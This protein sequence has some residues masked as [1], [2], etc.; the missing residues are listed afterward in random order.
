MKGFFGL[1]GKLVRSAGSSAVGTATVLGVAG[2]MT[3]GTEG[4]PQLQG[5]TLENPVFEVNE[6]R[7]LLG[8]QLDG[9]TTFFLI[10]GGAL[11]LTLIAAFCCTGWGC[12]A[13]RELSK[14][15]AK[16]KGMKE[17]KLEQPENREIPKD[18]DLESAMSRLRSKMGRV[19]RKGTT[20]P[21]RGGGRDVFA[22]GLE[23]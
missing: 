21:E 6:S 11:I 18:R 4:G 15:R 23:F 14:R 19:E 3:P 1:I 8:L 10:G 5:A 20:L 16:Q 7:S 13:C 22:D 2:A 12:Q 17:E 9:G